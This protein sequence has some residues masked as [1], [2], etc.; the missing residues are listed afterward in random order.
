M[1]QLVVAA[2]VRDALGLTYDVSFE[3]SLFDRLPHG[4]FVV[5]VTSTPQ[6]IHEAMAAS[7][8][9]LRTV[10]TQRITPRELQR[11]KR[12][13]LTRHE[14]EIKVP[15]RPLFS[16]SAPRFYTFGSTVARAAATTGCSSALAS[17]WMIQQ[18]ERNFSSQRY[19]TVR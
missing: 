10:A 1:P 19:S 7:L 11:A 3:L 9:V 14:S 12:T 17:S 8:R 18:Q 13:V 4:W 5:N 15:L 16:F 2:Q 6:K